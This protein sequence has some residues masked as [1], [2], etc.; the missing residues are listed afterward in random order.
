MQMGA[1][2]PEAFVSVLRVQNA[3]LSRPEKSLAL[4]STQ[5]SLASRRLR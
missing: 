1:G 3:A 4:A 2:F 5:K